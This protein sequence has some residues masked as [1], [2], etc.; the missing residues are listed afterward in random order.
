VNRNLLKIDFCIL[1]CTLFLLGFGVVLVY[2]SSFPLA[3]LRFGGADFFLARQ[4]V[5]ALLG[6]VC[7]VV[8][9]NIDY[10]VLGKYSHA[11][12]IAAL[13]LLVVVLAMPD[14]MAINGAK[15]WIQ[16]GFMRF[17]VSELARIALI[18]VFA[19][20]FQEVGERIREGTV[21]FRQIFKLALV[22]ALVALEPDFSTA[23]MVAL[24]GLSLLFIAG[25]NFWHLVSMGVAVVPVALLAIATTP[26][27]RDR[28]M[29]FPHMASHKQD[30]GYQAHQALIGLG[31]GGLFGVGLGGAQRKLFYLPEPHTDFVFSILGEEIGFI[32][33][34]V[35]FA[36]FALM[37]YRGMRIALRAPDKMGQTMAFGITFALA[38]YVLLHSFVNTGLVPT[39]GVPLPFLSYGGMSLIFT[40]SSMGILLNISSQ[41]NKMELPVS[42]RQK[43]LRANKRPVVKRKRRRR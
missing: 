14:S 30:I 18:I 8:F 4:T 39:T 28:I 3:Q 2:S 23:F 1:A 32:G 38:A 43:S 22:C 25:A 9:I 33:L 7:F 10:H 5:R 21:F 40:M 15:R 24:T 16:L 20:Q 27:R 11:I 34:L 19:A 26:Y 29:A 41:T 35:V 31:N 6:I 42:H 13:V 36:V 17:Q 37:I 12:F